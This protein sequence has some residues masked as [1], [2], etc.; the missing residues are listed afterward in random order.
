MQFGWSAGR[1]CVRGGGHHVPRSEGAGTGTDGVRA[2]GVETPAAPAQP[3]QALTQRVRIVLAC[4]EPGATNLCVDGKPQIGAVQGTAPT[5]RC[6]RARLS[7]TR[8][9]GAAMAR[10]T[11]SLRSMSGRARS[12][13]ASSRRSS[14]GECHA[15]LPMAP[16]SARPQR[17]Q[18]HFCLEIR[19]IP[20]PLAYHSG[21]VLLTGRP[22]LPASP[23]SGDLLKA[24]ATDRR[25]W[26]ADRFER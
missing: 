14:S 18:R 10:W 17:L 6:G 24:T 5:S 8:T 13:A 15:W 23:K 9:T 2:G 20:R 25:P 26:P 22:S 1:W 19:R 21:S 7:G 16:S 4:A 3:G 12:S 11:C